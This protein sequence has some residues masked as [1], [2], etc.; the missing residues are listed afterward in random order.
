MQS[1]AGRRR[2]ATEV[3]GGAGRRRSATGLSRAGRRRSATGLSRA[4]RRLSA[5]GVSRAG[6]RHSATEVQGGADALDDGRCGG[7][8]RASFRAQPPDEH[9][10][11]RTLDEAVDT[12][13]EERDTSGRERR[14]NRDDALDD[15]PS[16][17]QILETQR[18]R[19][20]AGTR[21]RRSE[22]DGF[23][24][25]LVKDSGGF[26]NARSACTTMPAASRTDGTSRRVSAHAARMTSA[27]P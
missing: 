26:A 14:R 15:V 27:T 13:R 18:V 2:S 3:Q 23:H 21:C 6:R 20:R 16:D 10:A 5:T 1:R 19:K 4:G 25:D 24:E 17:G 22:Q 8:R 9:R 7:I 11:R 12:K